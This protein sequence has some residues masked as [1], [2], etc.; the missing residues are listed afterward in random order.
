[1]LFNHL[2]D[3]RQRVENAGAGFAVDQRDVSDRRVGVQQAVDVGGGSGFVFSGFEGAEVAAEH[4]ADLRQALAVGAVDQHQYL[5]VAR[6][7]G[8]NG[9]FDGKGAAALQGHAVVAV[10][11]VQDRQQLCA[12]AGGQLVEAVIP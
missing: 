3:V 10:G 9:R 2:R 11:G 6:H 5:A 12:D 8:A 4:F 1:M 7:E